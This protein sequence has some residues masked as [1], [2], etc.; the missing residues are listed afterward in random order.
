[1]RRQDWEL[2]LFSFV[3]T[4]YWA[5]T[6]FYVQ[7]LPSYILRLGGS[8]ATVGYVSGAYGL[9]QAILRI[10]TGWWSDRLGRRMPLII[11]GFAAAVLANL[12]FVLAAAPGTLL[13]ARAMAGVS[14]TT[15]AIMTVYIAGRFPEDRLDATMGFLY[16]VSNVAQLAAS[17]LGAHM[18]ESWGWRAPFFASLIAGAVG[19]ALLPLLGREQRQATSGKT[20][21]DLGRVARRPLLLFVSLLGI[22]VQYGYWALAGFGPI[23]AERLGASEG[24][25]GNLSLFY[26][27]PAILVSL[28]AGR[29]Q[30]T[31]GRKRTLAAGFALMTLGLLA[32]PS[33]GS[34]ASLHLM[35]AL[36]GAG[37]GVVFPMLMSLSVWAVPPDRKG[38]AMGIF[39]ALYAVGMFLGPGI[40]GVY[41]DRYSLAG[42][43]LLAGSLLAGGGLAAF[44][45]LPR[46]TKD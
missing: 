31:L 13:F 36:S 20:W 17:A 21:G 39:S 16:A 45:I 23:V 34:L 4:A 18:A 30:T 28:A 5:A 2:L 14:S 41:A 24:A 6:Y 7:I 29:L 44:L 46:W 40:S 1:M 27:G 37:R 19:L 8:L 38:T 32:L 35:L 9:T 43:F 10:P 11:G 26:M 15:W 42:A 25:L 22:L 12:L 3:T 33:A